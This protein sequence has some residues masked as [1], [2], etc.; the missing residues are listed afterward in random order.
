MIVLDL[1]PATPAD[2]ELASYIHSLPDKAQMVVLG[3]WFGPSTTAAISRRRMS[4]LTATDLWFDV[5]E[6]T[7]F[8]GVTDEVGAAL[9]ELSEGGKEGGGIPISLGPIKMPCVFLWLAASGLPCCLLAGG[10]Q[11]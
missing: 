9:F 8:I 4:W 6:V 1:G 11:P 10:R 2:D 7:A 3:R 5:E